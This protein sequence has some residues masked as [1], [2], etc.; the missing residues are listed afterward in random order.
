MKNRKKKKINKPVK[1]TVKVSNHLS[2]AQLEA[3]GLEAE[4]IYKMFIVNMKKDLNDQAVYNCV[5]EWK[6][7]I[8]KYYYECSDVTLVKL[9]KLYITDKRFTEDLEQF[10][11]GLAGF[12]SQAIYAYVRRTQPKLLIEE[13]PV[14]KTV[15]KKATTKK[16]T[17]KKTEAKATTK[18]AAPKKEAVEP[19]KATAK[20]E[21]EAPK[22]APVKKA[23][24]KPKK[25]EATPKKAAAK[26]APAKKAE[27]KPAAKKT[28]KKVKE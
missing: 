3:I 20:K 10:Q 16:A 19:K 9:A 26:K 8:S 11:I 13:E 14:K 5:I 27:A 12:M 25:E 21:V 4:R 24:A 2:E 1:K 6:N 18:K 15:A 28:T 7:Y 17:E 23:A 22:K